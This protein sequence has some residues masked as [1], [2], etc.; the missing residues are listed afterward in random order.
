M[1]PPEL[2]ISTI[3]HKHRY[4]IYENL[5]KCF[6]ASN[7]ALNCILSVKIEALPNSTLM[8]KCDAVRGMLVINLYKLLLT[9]SKDTLAIR[10]GLNRSYT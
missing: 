5:T 8:T 3:T 7:V 1:F 6:L 2:L 9:I 10:L 4:E